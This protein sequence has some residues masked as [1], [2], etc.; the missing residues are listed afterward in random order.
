MHNAL[1]HPISLQTKSRTQFLSVD[2]VFTSSPTL[3]TRNAGVN[4]TTPETLT[5]ASAAVNNKRVG[6]TNT[7]SAINDDR[8]GTVPAIPAPPVQFRAGNHTKKTEL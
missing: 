4:M 6:T 3:A 2:D 8:L 7:S 1:L 5:A